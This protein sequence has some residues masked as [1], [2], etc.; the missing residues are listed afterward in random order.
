MT[1]T[2]SP[3]AGTVQF[4]EYS[5]DAACRELRRA[6]QPVEIQ[7]R[8]FDLLV[9]L[10]A[11]R[12]RAVDKDELQEAVWPGVVVTETALTRAIMKARKA[13]GDDAQQ[14]AVIR[15]VHG[16]GYRFV[17]EVA[18]ASPAAPHPHFEQQP[19]PPAAPGAEAE[20]PAPAPALTPAPRRHPLALLAL[21]LCA[22]LAIGLLGWWAL[23]PAP[24]IDERA[25]VAVLPLV[26]DTGNPELA[27]TRLGLMSLVSNQLSAEDR[28]AV[29][30]DGSVLGLAETLDWRGDLAA[31]RSAELVDKLR[32]VYGADYLV[33]MQL[34]SEG[35]ALRL[36]LSLLGPDDRLRQAT[37]VGDQPAGLA[38][39]VVQSLY[40]DLLNARA[41]HFNADPVSSDAFHN[42]AFARGMDLSLQGR[43]ADA[44]TYFRLVM[45][46]EPTL[47]APRY[48]Y[49]ACE[50]I[51]GHN[52]EAEQLLDALA[53]ELR[54]QGADRKLAQVLMTLG[55]I[56]NR[57]G[58][59]DDAEASHREALHTAGA[60][61]DRELSG[62]ILQNLSIVYEDRGD[63]QQA[64]EMLDLAVLE[65]HG[66][67]RETLPGQLYSARANLC[68]D[69]GEL[70]EARDYLEQAL[71]S[72]RASGDLR[73]EAMML[74][75]TGY[76]LREMGRLDEAEDYHLR[77]LAL[78]EDIG[79]R[80]GVGRVYGQLSALYST[81]GK[82]SEAVTAAKSAHAIALE[83]H[84]RLFE[85][86]SL[87]QWATAEQGL[88]ERAAAR[89]HLLQAREIFADI[90]DRMRVLQSDLLLARLDLEEGQ[91]DVAEQAA[92]Q[93]EA[94]AREA[95][96]N[97][98]EVEAMALLGETAEARGDHALAV[99]RYRAA[100]A[101]VRESNWEGKE[102]EI[103]AHLLRALVTTGD[104]QAA[105]PLAGAL[106]GFDATPAN[107]SARA[108][109]AFA[110][111]DSTAAVNLMEQARALAGTNWDESAASELARYRQSP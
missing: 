8:V 41:R 58:R 32:E 18:P 61:G 38:Q 65:Y 100:L 75:N 57:T 20:T 48:Q 28:I 33:A 92:V 108:N 45:E 95:N 50:R 77:S 104:L 1:T 79:D 73:S 76:L 103:V 59:L 5:I 87:A 52:D 19:A 102:A 34:R 90:Q 7:P 10:V 81:Q 66:A 14:Q 11:H 99:E 23:R 2:A 94:A 49:A 84:D 86:T 30:A 106:A 72:F 105:A 63:F 37:M 83:T 16:H 12:D 27:W 53:S 17:A 13:V 22:M 68:M 64:E 74:N 91:A 24:A 35:A 55:V 107:L 15:T 51:L 93:I 46:R 89:G 71:Q 3:G 6:N 70:A 101:R 43:C 29:V 4:G 110:S 62:R 42:E 21:G 60:I 47:F 78:R 9:Y 82:Y 96:L 80:V 36:N 44:N 25:R 88:G 98:P 69:R 109:Y 56:Y 31:E 39:G 85:A 67:G 111:G 97:Q 54:P 40:G 26:D